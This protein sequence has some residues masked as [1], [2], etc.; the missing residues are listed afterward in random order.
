MGNKTSDKPTPYHVSN[1]IINIR[2]LCF[3]D[4]TALTNSL[5]SPVNRVWKTD[6]D[7]TVIFV[8]PVDTAA[9]TRRTV[10]LR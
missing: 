2:G 8:L 10:N 4:V 6:G 3:E 9:V 5:A 7:Q 1:N